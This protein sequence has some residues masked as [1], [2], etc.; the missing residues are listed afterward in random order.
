LNPSPTELAETEKRNRHNFIFN[1]LDGTSFWFGYSF[2]APGVILPLYVSHYTNN[3][4]LIGLV[5]VISTMGYLVPQLFTA[6][7]VQRLPIK[8]VLPVNVGLFTERLPLFLLPLTVLVFVHNARVALVSFFLLF[9][10]HTIGAGVIAVAWNDMIAKIIPIARRGRFMG[11]QGFSG[12]AM[13]VIGASLAAW[14]LDHYAFPNGYVYSFAIG[15]V[16]VFFSWI[17][18][19]QTREL[20]VKTQEQ[21]VSHRQFWSELPALMRS[22]RNFTRFILCMAVVNLSGLAWG[23]LAVY[24]LK[25][26]NLLDGDVSLYN[27]TLLVG[28]AAGNVIFG[29][30]A[31]R[32]GYKLVLE[33]SALISVLA[34]VIT[35]VAPSA[36]WFH[37]VFG[38]RGISA[39]GSFLGSMIALEF[40]PEAIRPTYIGLNN[41]SS[42]I[43]TGGAPLIGGALASVMGYSGMF[44]VAVVLG[45]LGLV[46]LH[47]LVI[48]PRNVKLKL[49]RKITI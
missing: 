16:F 14:L 44:Q 48:E 30:L 49:E 40:G 7:W 29:W 24:T 21:A 38:L 22:D 12:Q 6:N 31:D 47:F 32:R 15:A 2:I 45:C 8:K 3:T 4:V 41:T 46:L 33:L 28:T 9:A 27:I 20:P 39:G 11:I 25:H 42:G 34:V 23:F 5:A 18:I 19:A 36:I 26:W 1:I 35:I 10:W 13:G 17:F 43:V 37:L